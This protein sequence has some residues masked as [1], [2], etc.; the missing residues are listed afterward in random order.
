[1]NSAIAESCYDYVMVIT[2]EIDRKKNLTIFT[3][4]LQTRNM[5]ISKEKTEDYI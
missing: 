5:K 2:D 1:M 4:E 3:K